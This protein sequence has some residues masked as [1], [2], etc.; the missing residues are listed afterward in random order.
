MPFGDRSHWLQP[1]RSFLDTPRATQLRD[2]VGINFNVSAAEAPAV[3][4][5]LA[6]NGFRRAR[7]EIAWGDLNYDDPRTM[8][9]ATEWRT[10]IRALRD[11]GLRPLVLL[12]SDD[13]RP[14]PVKD[15]YL[16]LTSAAGPGA[17]TVQLDAASAAKVVPGRTGFTNGNVR[18]DLIIASLSGTTATLSKPLPTYVPAGAYPAATLRHAPFSPVTRADGGVNPGGED[19]MQG[20]IDYVDTVTDF[21]RAELGS[22]QFDVEVSNEAILNSAFWDINRYYEPD[23]F[24]GRVAED[25][26]VER[27]VNWVKD[28]ANDLPGVRITNGFSSQR[29]WD[30][31]ATSPVG[32]DAL[33]KHYY[34][35]YLRF[36]S[37]VLQ[38]NR[39]IDALGNVSGWHSGSGWV[40]T[41]NP[42]YDTFFPEF[43][44]T[45][46][47]TESIIRDSGPITTRFTDLQGRSTEHGRNVKNAAGKPVEL[48]MTEINLETAAGKSLTALTYADE[49]HLRAKAALRTLTSYVNK[50][51][52]QI[53]FYSA[54]TQE[55]TLIGK[56]F[57]DALGSTGTYPGDTTGGPTLS[58]IRRLTSTL[59]AGTVTVPR[60]LTLASIGDYGGR[61]QF[62]GDGSAARPTLYDR[63]VLAF[64]PFQA[65]DTRFV[66]P[67]YVMT[68]N[69]AKVHDTS[70][71][72]SDPKRFDLPAERYQLTIGGTD[73]RNANVSA[74]DPM[75][76]TSVPVDVVRRTD[77]G[78]LVVELPVTD[79]PRLLVIDEG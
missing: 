24:P 63:D 76:G 2:A 49:E 32:L 57:W 41:H 6:A 19:T 26:I 4:R 29:P 7:I 48:W 30:S 39:P 75:T 8:W 65:S 33:S 71:P 73:A 59:N 77:S 25:T 62:Y 45:A 52:T 13:G 18:A 56:T 34:P 20:W 10:K 46:I 16:R 11:A 35:R 72:T 3:A 43:S 28:P 42:Q 60:K 50:G 40:D 47:A 55:W 58:G 68:R 78:W 79:S 5:L 17:R 31:A 54:G 69:M 51:T 70:A 27:T 22:T 66:V 1:W 53:D 44:L 21:V 12:N 38:G 61:F 36:P 14:A 15:E 37:N 74:V 67:V 23:L 9:R 64:L